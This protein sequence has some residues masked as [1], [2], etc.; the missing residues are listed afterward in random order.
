V[1]PAVPLLLGVAG[2]GFFGV[3]L[4]A[5]SGRRRGQGQVITYETPAQIFTPAYTPQ[6]ALPSVPPAPPAPT[7]VT[8]TTE[9]GGGY[10]PTTTIPKQLSAAIVASARKWAAKRGVPT[11]EILAT[12]LVESSGK[13]Y[14]WNCQPGPKPNAC[15]K[16]NSR[17]LMQVNINA[18]MPLLKANGM[19]V[20]DLYD[21]DK[22]IMIGSY[23]YAKYRKEV[24][25]L[26]AQAG[27]AQ[28][29]P[30]GTITRLYYKGPKYVRDK[31][32]AGKVLGTTPATRPYKQTEQA[33]ANWDNAM[34]KVSG[35]A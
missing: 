34:A 27:V 4:Y 30:I 31:I 3:M 10:V 35:I 28:T 14:A 26:I 17:G 8:S 16:E 32:L 24:Q 33:V 18:W 5:V 6:A 29:L 9:P 15:T 2:L 12:I 25:D 7:P 20:D 11:Q 21:I 23:I 13:Q 19:T 22:N 1:R